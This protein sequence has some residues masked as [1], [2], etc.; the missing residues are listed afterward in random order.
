[1]D[2]DDKAV[3]NQRAEIAPSTA[4]GEARHAKLGHHGLEDTAYDAPH[5]MAP[6]N[7]G[8]VCRPCSDQHLA[9]VARELIPSGRLWIRE[10]YSKAIEVKD[11]SASGCCVAPCNT[12]FDLTLAAKIRVK[13]LSC[14]QKTPGLCCKAPHFGLI[15]QLRKRLTSVVGSIRRNKSDIGELLLAFRA[16]QHCVFAFL[17]GEPDK[18]KQWKVFALCQTEEARPMDVYPFNLRLRASDN[19]FV[20]ATDYSLAQQLFGLVPE[21]GLW[22]ASALNY[23]DKP[24]KLHEVIVHG[25]SPAIPF[26]DAHHA[27]AKASQREAPKDDFEMMWEAAV[28]EKKEAAPSDDGES[29]LSSDS[30]GE[31]LKVL[32][33]RSGSDITDLDQ[34][35]EELKQR[36]T[37]TMRRR[38]RKQPSGPSGPSGPGAPS[39]T[40]PKLVRVG[41]TV[42]WDGRKVARITAWGRNISCHCSLHPACKAPALGLDRIPSD[43]VFVEWILNAIDH[44]GRPVVTREQ[45]LASAQ[46]LKEQY[47]RPRGFSFSFSVVFCLAWLSMPLYSLLLIGSSILKVA[48]SNIEAMLLLLLFHELKFA[49]N[50]LERFCRLE[51]ITYSTSKR[52]TTI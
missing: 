44:G 29:D 14:H 41:P 50:A 35:V 8:S 3:W 17:V 45:H 18:R 23:E 33:E 25:S 26:V 19:A 51:Y 1:M 13:H 2:E 32:D 4:K 28:E 15:M 49:V 12:P 48:V 10:A 42:L 27:R 43:A 7:L 36:R 9:S 21:K 22:K 16:R 46:A 34:A 5:A 24:E 38:K 40:N 39:V 30:S 20:E 31:A 11:P 6:W 52:A 37:R 47:G